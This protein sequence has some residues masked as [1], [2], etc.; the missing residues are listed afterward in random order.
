MT[1]LWFNRQMILFV[2]RENLS[3]TVSFFA[4]AL[5][6]VLSS[7]IYVCVAFSTVTL[8]FSIKK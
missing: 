1:N 3:L 4:S 2:M 8:F 5:I 7:E 6:I